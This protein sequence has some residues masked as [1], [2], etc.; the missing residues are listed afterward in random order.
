MSRQ[1]L[2][3]VITVALA[4][5]VYGQPRQLDVFDVGFLRQSITP[6]DG[7]ADAVAVEG[8]YAYVG[9]GR[10]LVVVDVADPRRPTVVG[11]TGFWEN[12][13]GWDI[14]G[15]HAIAVS[16][17]HAYVVYQVSHWGG[18]D[19]VVFDAWQLVNDAVEGQLP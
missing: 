3:V 19:M 14:T 18:H 7:H 1:L 11:H 16:G 5:S 12:T 8:K 6:A 2:A 9:I 4:S 17:S 13:R 15:V 10:W